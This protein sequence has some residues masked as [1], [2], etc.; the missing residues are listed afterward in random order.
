MM[1]MG[2]F[3]LMMVPLSFKTVLGPGVC[4]ALIMGS[5]SM[6]N[7]TGEKISL[8]GV[9]AASAALNLGTLTPLGVVFSI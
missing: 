8:S 5:D 6:G 2:I 4:S 7:C 9:L 1:A 3:P